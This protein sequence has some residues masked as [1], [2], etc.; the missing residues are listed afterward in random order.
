MNVSII[1]PVYNQAETLKER[2][3]H[4][5]EQDYDDF[6]LILVDDGSTDGCSEICDELKNKSDKIKVF[7][8]LNGGV[9]SARNFGIKEAK[10]KYIVFCD[11]DDDMD[12][13][14]LSNL[15][16][17]MERTGADLV[18]GGFTNIRLEDSVVQ[19]E[20]GKY[21]EIDLNN[22][23]IDEFW[24]ENTVLSAC[25]KMF[26]KS[27]ILT[28]KMAFNE[29]MVVL[30]DYC[31]VLEYLQYCRKIVGLDNPV[32]NRYCT[33]TLSSLSRRNRIDFIDDVVYADNKQKQFFCVH[34]VK[35][36]KKC[37]LLYSSYI[38]SYE[39]LW[40]LKTTTIIERFK[41]Y[42]RI[43]QVLKIPAYKEV[44]EHYK[45]DY[46]P[47]RYWSLKHASVIGILICNFLH[48]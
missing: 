7:H 31:F 20:I 43:K 25:A 42:K 45:S 8:K 22:D 24:M 27:I 37:Q 40:T 2:M 46:S 19:T 17:C 3:C 18:A 36:V 35:D 1:V 39:W 33:S 6:E 23:Y 34:N 28:K 10:G 21:K 38:I 30:E 4:L 26:C 12:I 29:N 47:F 44:F 41:K 9:S 16:G 48:I 11:A 5:L 14:A 15:V 13:S 32:Y